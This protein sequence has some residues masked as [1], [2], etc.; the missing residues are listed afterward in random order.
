MAE[1]LCSDTF[2]TA[3][4]VTKESLACAWRW[5]PPLPRRHLCWSAPPSSCLVYWRNDPPAFGCSKSWSR[6][7]EAAAWLQLQE[8]RECHIVYHFLAN[9][10]IAQVEGRI[11]LLGFNT[12][13]VIVFWG[14]STEIEQNLPLDQL[15]WVSVSFNVCYRLSGFMCDL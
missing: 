2:S 6:L 9:L 13:T 12:N 4:L 5:Q 7:M 15:C 11:Y 3:L 1:C 8:E 10:S 14:I